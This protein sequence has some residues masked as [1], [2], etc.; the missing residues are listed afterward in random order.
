MTIF[1]FYNAHIVDPSQSIDDKSSSLLSSSSMPLFLSLAVHL[2]VVS[3]S[4]VSPNAF[5]VFAAVPLKAQGV[6]CQ[7]CRCSN[8]GA[9]AGCSA[10]CRRDSKD[11]RANK[12]ICNK[13][14]GRE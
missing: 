2:E 8:E 1:R 4:G 5:L 14:N 11:E 9:Q 10:L 13:F 12:D 3:T 7:R 6:G